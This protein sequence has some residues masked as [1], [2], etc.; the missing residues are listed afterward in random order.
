MFKNA[1]ILCLVSLG[2]FINNGIT[3]TSGDLNQAEQQI[4]AL[5]GSGDY[6]GADT[7]T[8]KLTTDFNNSLGIDEAVHQIALKHQ[9][10]KNYQKTIDLSRQVIANWPQSK[11]AGW[12]QM[13]IVM[14]NLYLHNKPAAQM[15]I[16]TL[17]SR[18]KDDPN[19]PRMLYLIGQEYKSEEFE[20]I[21]KRNF[22]AD[23]PAKIR[24]AILDVDIL[25]KIE[26]GD[27]D[28]VGRGVDKMIA[29]FAS[30]ADLPEVL[31]I[32]AQQLGWRHQYEQ[33]GNICRQIVQQYPTS[34][35]AAKAQQC[36]SKTGQITNI[37]SSL[38]E[39][40][41]YGKVGKAVEELI[42]KFGDEAD[43]P[44]T[45]FDIA[46]KLETAGKFD[47]AR[48][49]YG[50]IIWRYPKDKFADMSQIA[51][52]RTKVFSFDES[53]DETSAQSTFD[54]VLN[55]FKGNP[56]LPAHV[57]WT[58]EGY[59]RRACKAKE[60]GDSALA[61]KLFDKTMVTLDV[62]L[63]QFP[64]STEVPNA[65]YLEAECH[66]QLNDYQPAADLFQKVADGYPNFQ[67]ASNA[68]YMVAETY[69]VL[70]KAGAVSESQ[71]DSKTQSAYEK[72]LQKYPGSPLIAAAQRWL[73]KNS[74]K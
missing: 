49:V 52:Q 63:T 6:A 18:Y 27:Y 74:S 53:G 48:Q 54:D 45:I 2:G 37:V 13:D 61:K 3:E 16:S 47:L 69:Q 30:D 43:T 29:E 51:V 58:A 34:P 39:S 73:D 7:A 21:L 55:D 1:A 20:Q 56:Y 33:A 72:L 12:S 44:A 32:I 4:F 41:D 65:L 66:Y 40:G 25:A 64:A 23:S 11:H 10:V 38:I 31:L 28:A 24:L 46:G 57:I 60:N 62:V 8:N 68:L 70:K 71:A 35:S 42:A 50:Q 19:L 15:E 59:Y 14:A 17:I 26:S 5:I 36:I 67:M 9:A 22:N